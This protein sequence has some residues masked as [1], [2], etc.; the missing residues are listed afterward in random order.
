MSYGGKMYDF[1]RSDVIQKIWT[2]L[3]FGGIF[4]SAVGIGDTNFNCAEVIKCEII[5]ISTECQNIRR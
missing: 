1:S 2:F 5:D 3:V 4:L